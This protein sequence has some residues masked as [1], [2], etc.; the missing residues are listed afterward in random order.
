MGDIKIQ[1]TNI[2]PKEVETRMKNWDGSR[3]AYIQG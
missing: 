2:S 1:T 3:V